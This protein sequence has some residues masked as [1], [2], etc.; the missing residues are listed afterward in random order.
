M[1]GKKVFY[2]FGD[3]T[4]RTEGTGTI[5]DKVKTTDVV[6]N[7]DGSIFGLSQHDIYLIEKEGGAIVPVHPFQII[8]IV[9]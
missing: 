1:L 7:E 4:E 8:K 2:S 3:S 6:R 9:G 5:V